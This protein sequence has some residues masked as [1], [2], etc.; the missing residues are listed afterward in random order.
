MSVQPA[1]AF[2][3]EPYGAAFADSV[4]ANY[5]ADLSGAAGQAGMSKFP[6]TGLGD[7]MG[8]FAGDLGAIQGGIGGFVRLRTN[9]GRGTTRIGPQA[10]FPRTNGPISIQDLFGQLG[11]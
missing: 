1:I 2:G 11:I 5:G 10:A 8:D 4:Q 6:T 3:P 7:P 9:A